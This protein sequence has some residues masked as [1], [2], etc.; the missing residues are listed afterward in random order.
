[1]KRTKPGKHNVSPVNR[2]QAIL[3]KANGM[4][5]IKID[6][7]Q[8][9]GKTHASIDGVDYI[10]GT[11]SQV[12]TNFVVVTLIPDWQAWLY[13]NQI[14]IQ[15]SNLFDT[16]TSPNSFSQ[17]GD[18]VWLYE[19]NQK[20][21]I[22]HMM[23]KVSGKLRV[24]TLDL[25]N[26][27]EM[28]DIFEY[29][30]KGIHIEGGT[31][32]NYGLYPNEYAMN[33]TGHDPVNRYYVFNM[34]KCSPR[35]VSKIIRDELNI[36]DGDVNYITDASTFFL[37]VAWTDRY[38]QLGGK[39]ARQIMELEIPLDYKTG[40]GY[41]NELL[42][43]NAGEITEFPVSSVRSAPYYWND[44]QGRFRVWLTMPS[45][46]NMAPSLTFTK[47][48]DRS[49]PN[50][51]P[52]M[53]VP[54]P[55]SNMQFT[56]SQLYAYRSV[57]NNDAQIGLFKELGQKAL[58]NLMG[59]FKAISDVKSGDRT[60]VLTTIQVMGN[61]VYDSMNVEYWNRLTTLQNGAPIQ[62]TNSTTTDPLTSFKFGYS[63]PLKQELWDSD[64]A[65][66]LGGAGT[67]PVTTGWNG[68]IYRDG[69]AV[70]LARKVDL[71]EPVK[72]YNNGRIYDVYK[73]QG[74]PYGKI[75]RPYKDLV[76]SALG[77]GIT[78]I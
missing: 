5:T 28:A 61:L 69:Y 11:V 66:Y 15:E 2:V 46:T 70:D 68:S 18:P 73:L 16:R 37:P 71:I 19:V 26:E 50:P 54:L 20:D 76:V 1:M 43:Y 45:S 39:L 3:D 59:A 58:D 6:P 31:Q 12:N 48:D 60:A 62:M 77:S 9:S 25:N 21:M 30:V 64:I 67:P 33:V 51:V 7:K 35:D 56:M 47:D 22:P 53:T 8:L 63:T 10:I 65:F 23:I 75:P 40:I 42:M 29:Q 24:P 57:N 27:E 34:K 74:K 44:R 13:D 14:K 38:N 72:D 41:T 17:Y 49:M 78:F 52:I 32:A 36:G 55:F 4:A